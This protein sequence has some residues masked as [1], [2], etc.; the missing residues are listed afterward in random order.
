VRITT[1]VLAA[2]I[3]FAV[4][5]CSGDE[6][7]GP[8]TESKPSPEQEAK[9]EA[10]PEPEA[11][12]KP[13][14]KQEIE[15]RAGSWAPLFAA[16]ADEWACRYMT[17]PACE[18]VACESATAGCTPPPSELRKSFEDATVQDIALK[19][20]RATATFSNGEVVGLQYLS[21][22]EPD[23]TWQINRVGANEQ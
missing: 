1:A 16:S 14:P 19:G 18:Q 8:A 11:G 6:G 17:Q 7:D 3:A 22:H 12:G 21:E 2:A 10:S 20:E 13:S 4:F 23:G 15:E 9:A 5:G